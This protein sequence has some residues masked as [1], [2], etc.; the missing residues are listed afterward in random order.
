MKV[1]D[2]PCGARSRT[3]KRHTPEQVINLLLAIVC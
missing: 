2:D 3:G 1:F